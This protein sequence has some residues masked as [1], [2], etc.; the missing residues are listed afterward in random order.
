M[1]TST[2]TTTL[3]L[4][5]TGATVSAAEH[6]KADGVLRVQGNSWTETRV[7][8]V[9]NNND[10][11]EFE[12]NSEKFSMELGLNESYMVSFENPGCPT[13]QIIFDTNVPE[14]TATREFSFPFQVTLTQMP[15]DAQFEYAGPVG[16]VQ[17]TKDEADFTYTTDYN[18]K[19]QERMMER[20]ELLRNAGGVRN[21]PKPSVASAA[22]IAAV[23]HTAPAPAPVAAIAPVAAPAVVRESLDMMAVRTTGATATTLGAVPAFRGYGNA[24]GTSIAIERPSVT[25][26]TTISKKVQPA[27][28]AKVR[29][30][31][32]IA[33]AQPANCN[34]S[35]TITEGS[36]IVRI[37]RTVQN[38][39]CTE[40]RKVSHSYGGVFFFQDGVSI[41]D[42]EYTSAIGMD[43]LTSAK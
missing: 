3:L 28:A 25:P 32:V 36:R 38:G 1:K 22:V 21:A 31:T 27:V 5:A 18:V 43:M 19:D 24:M 20:L 6:V 8:V 35:E 9:S 34:E 26:A 40:L 41:T 2:L 11:Y 12:L 30:R 42:R 7:F 4:A 15:A 16:F 33:P 13:K 10:G 17:Y 37:T 23:L 39:Q 14:R 29:V